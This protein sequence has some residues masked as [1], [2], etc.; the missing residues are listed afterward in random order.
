VTGNDAGGGREAADPDALGDREA[1]AADRP[2]DPWLLRDDQFLSEADREYVLRDDGWP[3]LSSLSALAVGVLVG[4]M[5]ADVAAIAA[6]AAT[7]RDALAFLPPAIAAVGL[8]GLLAA[9]VGV[10]ALLALAATPAGS[11]RRRAGGL[12]D[13]LAGLAGFALVVVGVAVV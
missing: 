5:V 11:G 2:G 10:A 9:K 12:A 6:A 1:A 13:A 8:R 3:W 7:G 4:L